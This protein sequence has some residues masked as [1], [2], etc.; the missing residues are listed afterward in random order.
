V[1]VVQVVAMLDQILL[2]YVTGNE[3][4]VLL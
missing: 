2:F 3:Q 4:E 1:D